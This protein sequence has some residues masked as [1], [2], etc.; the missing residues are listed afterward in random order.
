MIVI[1][2]QTLSF[3]LKLKERKE[4]CEPKGTGQQMVESQ[5]LLDSDTTT[6]RI[7]WNCDINMTSELHSDFKYKS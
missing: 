1:M 4:T 5:G 6:S 7:F 2:I 3:H